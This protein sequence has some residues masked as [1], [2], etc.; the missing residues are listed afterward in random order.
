MTPLSIASSNGDDEGIEALIAA[1]GD[2]TILHVTS[3]SFLDR[4]A[5][6]PFRIITEVQ[7]VNQQAEG[8]ES[9]RR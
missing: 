5:A 6:G 4:P 2:V 8:G 3:H 7:G 9:R 1:G